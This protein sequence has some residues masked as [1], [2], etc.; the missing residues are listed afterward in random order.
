MKR[1]N[2]LRKRIPRNIRADWRKYITLCLLLIITISVT[3]AM[4]V[5]NNSMERAFLEGFEEYN[6][7]DG[8]F[9]FNSKAEKKQIADERKRLKQEEKQQQ[10]WTSDFLTGDIQVWI[11][12]IEAAKKK[13]IGSKGALKAI[14]TQ[15]QYNARMPITQLQAQF[16]RHL[17]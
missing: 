11:D 8:H 12:R 13:F 9:E 14:F 1:K 7:E 15:L 4:Y 6:I 10:T 2:P 17:E 5:G 3:C 16:S